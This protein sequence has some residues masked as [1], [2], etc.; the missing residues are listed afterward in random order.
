MAA[1]PIHPTF[2][3]SLPAIAF[4]QAVIQRDH[5]EDRLSVASASFL[6]F[7]NRHMITLLWKA[8]FED[9]IDN[10][11]YVLASHGHGKTTDPSK[12]KSSER[13]TSASFGTSPGVYGAHGKPTES[14]LPSGSRVRPTQGSS[15]TKGG[16]NI[17]DG[18]GLTLLHHIASSPSDNAPAFAIGLLDVPTLD[19]YIQDAEN[20]WTALHRALYFGN[21][22][23][24]HTI[25][26]LD[27]RI[28]ADSSRHI[29][30]QVGCLIKIK[31]REGNSPFDLYAATIAPRSIIE[32]S[33][34]A[35]IASLS[36]DDD[37]PAQG[38]SGDHDDEEKRAYEI[39]AS[40]NIGGDE[41]FVFGSNQ[42]LTLG[43]GDEDDRQ[44]PERIQLSRP[45]R[46][47]RRLAAEHQIHVRGGNSTKAKPA[48]KDQ[49]DELPAC[50]K[51]KPIIIQDV[52]MS[53]LHTA[54][55]TSDVEANLYVCGFG[56]GGR[57]GTGDENTRFQYV[58][59]SGGALAGKKV[60][61]VSLG[62]NHTVAITSLGETTTWG[63]NTFGQLGYS[64]PGVANHDEAKQLLPKQLFGILKKEC[65]V[66]A[67]ASR[68]HTVVHTTHSL[69]TFGK[70][71]GQLGL[72]D[73]DARSLAV[74]D[75]PRKI[76][77]S[78]FTS[79]IQS[80]AAI[81]HAT[82][83]LL[84]THEVWIFANYGY[85]K[86]LIDTD[87]I[88]SHFL[89]TSYSLTRYGDVNNH[90]TKIVAKRDTICALTS[91]GEVFFC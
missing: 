4:K 52:Q 11:L 8:F 90:V 72:V 56:P 51:F 36:E 47:T 39:R 45:A 38:T 64:T 91:M 15:L 34:T 59:V 7:I 1:S 24:A 46:L 85:T 63:N 23:I 79:T 33:G 37:G 76:A 54:I 66:G 28:A 25:L 55:L 60:V 80:V 29:N 73:S 49:V 22:T 81:D 78:L 58:S 35:L 48:A 69:Y 61:H 71:D 30:P 84:E 87:T 26:D 14:R 32:P 44:F 17:R 27:Y 18:N 62:Q 6:Q 67:A 88:A 10:F 75:T 21:I 82:I 5:S 53:K 70:N 9:D 77:A 74:Q 40:T 42:N 31:D 41:L 20:G 13:T 12:G 89:R 3:P 83:C 2:L 57:L 68:F 86:L 19:L 16:I 50:I 65:I 43:L